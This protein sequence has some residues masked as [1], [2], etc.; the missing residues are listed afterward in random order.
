MPILIKSASAQ[1]DL[2]KQNL[3]KSSKFEISIA[4]FFRKKLSIENLIYLKK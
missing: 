3:R 1:Y 4:Q 2:T